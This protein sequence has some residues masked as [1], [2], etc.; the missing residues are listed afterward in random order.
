MDIRTERKSEV[1]E[2]IISARWFYIGGIFV[3]GLMS[4][5]LSES[6]VNFPIWLMAALLIAAV[7]VN[8]AMYAGMRQ[9]KAAKSARIIESIGILQIIFELVFFTILMHFA[10]GIESV[11]IIFYF[12]P[13]VSA[14]LI[15]GVRGAVYTALASGILINLLHVS[16]YA[17]LI[18]HQPRY[19][20]PT[21]EFSDLSIALTKTITVSIFYFIVGIFSGYGSRLL[22]AREQ[23]LM[24]HA[25][26]LDRESKQRAKQLEQLDST[27][28]LLV[29][30]DLELT[31][32]N[33]ELDKKI[34]EIEKSEAS[35]MK[36]FR[37]IEN[38]RNKTLAIISNLTD[39]IIVLDTEHRINLF[40]HAAQEILGLTG[41]DI[42]VPISDK[43]SF[44]IENF[45]EVVRHEFTHK[46]VEE[47]K[48][49]GTITEE[50]AV[51]MGD[52]DITYK[53]LTA[54]VVDEE[55]RQ[56]GIMKVFYDLTREKM[57]DNMKSEFISIA[58]H[59]L[60]TP[61]SAI[62]WIMKM[63]LDEDAGALNQEQKDLLAKGYQSNERIIN[64]VNDLLNVSRIEEGRFGFNFTAIDFT[65]VLDVV[66]ESVEKI[67]EEHK[68]KLTVKKPENK[69]VV[70]A[71]KSRLIM[72]LQ[73]MVENSIK[74]TPELGKIDIEIAAIKNNM[75]RVAVKD[76]GVGIPDA[77][78]HKLFS[79]FFR[80]SNVIRME[81]EGTGLG[82]FIAKNIIE[83]HGGMIMVASE[84]G[85]GTEVAFTLPLH[86]AGQ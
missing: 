19:D 86:M 50:M 6:N 69:L 13:V 67:A 46:K 42:G 29:K 77:D 79:K 58:A 36:A 14:S 38:E 34:E 2:W 10:G 3:I 43:N 35:L 53:V 5:L 26:K 45:E 65:E 70:Y 12:I 71:D 16:E 60:R 82:L 31:K 1:N 40:N 76:N 78:K 63:V 56:L 85:K 54:N 72:V 37:D 44:S 11:A 64:L 24:K 49:L 4:R 62:K 75:M 74:Y 66:I 18:T 21:I 47:N 25:D 27:A 17:G 68:I 73:N 30:R 61:L 15:Y 20:E 83:K 55:R 57:I 48:T 9:A 22:F 52:H 32:I 8:T 7:G 41:A 39:P 81:T 33:S 80:A 84:E 51:K 23:L 28:R 59:Q